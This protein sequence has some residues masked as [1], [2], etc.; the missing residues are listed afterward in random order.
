MLILLHADVSVVGPRRRPTA[1]KSVGGIGMIL[2]P[3]ARSMIRTFGIVDL[4]SA[5]LNL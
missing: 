2:S 3:T 5:S 1:P 4:K